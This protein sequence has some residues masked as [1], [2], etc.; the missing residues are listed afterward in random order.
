MTPNTRGPAFPGLHPSKE[1]HYQ[2]SGMR[3]RDYFAAQ[4]MNALI[5]EMADWK[6]A[7][8]ALAK[9]AYAQAD[10]MLKVRGTP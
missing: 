5:L 10:A 7:P 9:Y 6:Y 2:D 3:L 4:A 8:E 1:C